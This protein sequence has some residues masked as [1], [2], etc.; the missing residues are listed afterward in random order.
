MKTMDSN[1]L[2]DS[3]TAPDKAK[4]REDLIAFGAKLAET[5][6]RTVRDSIK[7]VAPNQLYLGCRFAWVNDEAARAAGK[8][9]DVVS[10]NLYR[11]FSRRGQAVDRR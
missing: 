11:R 9:C 3:R 5:Y 10:Y 2:L 7:A 8:Y 1:A 6:F 4:A